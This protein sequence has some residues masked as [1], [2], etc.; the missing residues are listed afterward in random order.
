MTLLVKV[1]D[2]AGK[3]LSVVHIRP[4]HDEYVSD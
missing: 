3:L 4:I 1:C 2:H